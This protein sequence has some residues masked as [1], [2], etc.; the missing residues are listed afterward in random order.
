VDVHGR[1]IEGVKGVGKIATTSE[2]REEERRRVLF[3][4]R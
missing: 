1:A 3:S 4:T 2:E